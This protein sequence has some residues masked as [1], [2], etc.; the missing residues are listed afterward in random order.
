MAFT[1]TFHHTSLPVT[2]PERR[3]AVRSILTTATPHEPSEC[4]DA[5]PHFSRAAARGGTADEV[6]GTAHP[7]PT[8]GARRRRDLRPG[9]THRLARRLSRSAAQADHAA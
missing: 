6:R 5:R 8:E 3:P 9:V 7:R 4:V 1:T 2:S